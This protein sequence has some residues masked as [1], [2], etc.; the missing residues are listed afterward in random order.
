MKKLT[1]VLIGTSILLA[2][3][4]AVYFL[5][6]SN[7]KH[8]ESIGQK[9]EAPFEAKADAAAGTE[10][11]MSDKLPVGTK[12]DTTA[13]AESS[14]SE[15]ASAETNI[16]ITAEA[17]S[18]ASEKASA[19]TNIDV[20]TGME[21]VAFDEAP[22]ETS[23]EAPVA[24]GNNTGSETTEPEGSDTGTPT[25]AQP[26]R[27]VFTGDVELSGSVQSNYT[28]SGINGVLSERL[29]KI[30]TDADFTMINNEFCFSLRGEQNMEKQYTFR[31]DPS[32]VSLLTDAGVD[33]AGL[34]NN[35]VLDYGKT[36]LSDTFATLADAGI[37]YTGAG[38][39]LEEASKLIVKE[40]KD[41]RKI[42]FLAA[43]HVIPTADWNVTIS[44]PGEFCFYD[45]TDLINTI[46]ASK[47]KVDLLYVMVHWGVER[48]IELTDYQRTDA[49]RF[50]EA[51]ADA[52]IG[53][54]SHCL[55]PIEI[56]NGKP[57]FYSLGNFI[58]N[59]SIG[60]GGGGCVEVTIPAG[61]EPRYRIIPTHAAEALTDTDDNGLRYIDSISPDVSVD[62]EGYI[63][64]GQQ[65]E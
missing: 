4:L 19:E 62:A 6:G 43:G 22:A 64:G 33:I 25:E 52:V 56:Y 54:H 63:S 21:S 40:G 2:A 18:L 12:I 3:V 16:D 36:A 5:Y 32:Y 41:G 28:N 15:K 49:H 23:A 26:T 30:L 17:E 55:Q 7:R 8:V 59:R 48:T 37:D 39:T 57:V 13:E 45:E 38:N 53:M 29:H 11:Q 35:H 65:M 24:P 46:T 27:L 47:E 44:Q 61:E 20:T 14:A 31:V 60:T 10:S 9:T 51:G 58:F 42:G 1:L 50:I 34:A